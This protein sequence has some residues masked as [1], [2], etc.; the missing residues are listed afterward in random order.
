MLKDVEECVRVCE[1]K[2]KRFHNTTSS[3]VEKLHQYENFSLFLRKRRK[4]NKTAT[5]K[6]SRV[7]Q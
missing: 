4:V 1:G 7:I 5:L 3:K 2:R 6:R